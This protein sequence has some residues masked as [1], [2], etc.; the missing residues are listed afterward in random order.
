MKTCEARLGGVFYAKSL[1]GVTIIDG[2][3]A[4][5]ID[6]LL[7]ARGSSE[8][9]PVDACLAGYVFPNYGDFL[10]HGKKRHPGDPVIGKAVSHFRFPSNL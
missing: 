1:R 5:I 8:T 9:D 2:A 10:R 7:N 3:A 6:G 4:N